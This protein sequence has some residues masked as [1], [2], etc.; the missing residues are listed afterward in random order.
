MA[1]FDRVFSGIPAFDKAIDNIR[2][3]DNVVWRLNDLSEF[4]MFMKPYVK[5]A[6]ADGRNLIYIRFASHPPLLEEQE[7]LRVINVEL[8][9]KFEKFSV[10]IHN[11]I[12]REGYDAFYVFD[13]LSELQTAW[14]TDLMMGN[15]FQVTCP[16]LFKLD[17]VAFFP[18]IRGVHSFR[19]I[20]RILDTTQ[21]FF[22]VYSGAREVYV[23]PLKVWNRSSDTMMLPHVF[24]KENG[25][26][27]P[28]TDGVKSSRFYQ[29]LNRNRLDNQRRDSWDRFFDKAVS[30]YEDGIDISAECEIMSF[31]MMS[32]DDVLSSISGTG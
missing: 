22:D 27:S 23:R 21:L 32:R 12:E 3:G 15:F 30:K 24:N 13:C 8:T 9:H 10:A 31:T 29:V 28:I 7:G 5:Q 1:A 4:D 16:F 26:F 25:E 14:A 18:I 20:S 17:T 2:L 6:I 19:A 11:I